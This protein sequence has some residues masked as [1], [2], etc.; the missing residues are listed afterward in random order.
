[1][2]KRQLNVRISVNEYAAL[3]AMASIEATELC[4]CCQQ[5]W[6]APKEYRGEA[7]ATLAAKL[8]SEAIRQKLKS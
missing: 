5:E 8:L 4:P 1:M 7:I 3:K 2:K 6:K